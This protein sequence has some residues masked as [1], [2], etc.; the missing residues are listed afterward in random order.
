[1]RSH[2]FHFLTI[3]VL[4]LGATASLA[5]DW[6]CWRGRT[7]QG[8][9]DEKDLP[10][11]WGGKSN[12]NILWKVPLPGADGKGK[13]DHNQSS[14]IVWKDRIFLIMVYWPEGTPQKEAPEHHVACYQV[15]DGKK[16]WDTLVP[17]GPWL[18]SGPN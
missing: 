16:L 17:P 11:T 18:L 12:E 8:V 1:M 7:G 10:I 4:L 9:S 6:P 5:G 15:S 13:L 3:K 2:L 14:P